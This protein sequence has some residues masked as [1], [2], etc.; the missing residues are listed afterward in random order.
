[1]PSLTIAQG[2]LLLSRSRC[3]RGRGARSE[4]LAVAPLSGTGRARLGL[5]LHRKTF[6]GRVKEGLSLR[7][8]CS[9]AQ[10]AAGAEQTDPRNIGLESEACGYR[11]MGSWALTEAIHP[12]QWDVQR[13]G[14]TEVTTGNYWCLIHTYWLVSLVHTWWLFL[15]NSHPGFYLGM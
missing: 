14:G 15:L 2:S 1:M 8:L 4:F 10:G 11:V 6:G 7:W 3:T 9:Q 12:V 5:R 13:A